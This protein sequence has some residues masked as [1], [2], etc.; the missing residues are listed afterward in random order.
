MFRRRA[1]TFPESAS[2]GHAFGG[3]SDTGTPDAP[4]GEVASGTAAGT[5][6]RPIPSSNT[7]PGFDRSGGPWDVTEVASEDRTAGAEPDDG[8]DRDEAEAQVERLD[9]GALRI[10]PMPGLELRID[11]DEATQTVTSVSALLAGSALEIQAFAAP[12]HEGIWDEVRGEIADSIRSQHGSAQEADGPF[13]RE[14]RASVPVAQPDGR[15][16]R[17]SLR[18]LGVDGPRWFLRGVISGEAAEHPAVG[19]PLERLFRSVIVVRGAEAMAPRELIPLRLPQQFAA[20]L[21]APPGSGAPSSAP[22]SDEFAPFERGPEI[23]E[24]R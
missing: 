10:P 6:G 18:F 14:L 12:R 4:G 11:M 23:T 9:L 5:G 19:E 2:R 15:S 1:K 3:E 7:S 22:G 24:L 8:S 20:H 17:Q 16:L 13:G 21:P